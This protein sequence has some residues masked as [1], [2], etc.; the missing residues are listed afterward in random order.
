MVNGLCSFLGS[1]GIYI[2]LRGYYCIR[3]P[4][5]PMDYALHVV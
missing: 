1:K 4:N 5:N 3:N 2:D